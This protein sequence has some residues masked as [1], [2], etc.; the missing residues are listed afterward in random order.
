[1]KHV[2]SWLQIL[3][4]GGNLFD[5]VSLAVKAAL[6]NVRI[7]KVKAASLDGGTVDLQLSDDPFDCYHLDVS[8]APCLVTLCKVTVCCIVLPACI[9]LLFH[10]NHLIDLYC[11]ML[12]FYSCNSRVYG[13]Q[14]RRP[15]LRILYALVV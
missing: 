14:V 7:P 2:I 8:A 5:A 3:E 10:C 9:V 13:M 6:H 4:C 15:V 12:I 11:H 1:L